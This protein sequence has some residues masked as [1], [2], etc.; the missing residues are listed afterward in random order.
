MITKFKKWSKNNEK[1]KK[2]E[3]F[4]DEARNKGKKKQ[5]KPLFEEKDKKNLL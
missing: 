2:K 1:E 4:L 3:R 5:D